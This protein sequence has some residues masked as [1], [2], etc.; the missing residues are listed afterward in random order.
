MPF[1]DD[2]EL[3]ALPI[4]QAILDHPF[5]RGVGDGSLEV[6]KFKHYVLQDYVYLIEYSR[7]LAMAAARAQD[8]DTMGWFAR[9]LD[10]TLNIEMDL[11]RGYCAEFGITSVE[12]ETTVPAPTTVAYTAYLLQLAHQGSFAELVASLVPCQWGYWEIGEYLSRQGEPEDAPLYSQWIQ[13]YT[14]QEF[15]ELADAIR[16]LLDRLGSRAGPDELEAMERAYLTSLRFEYMF[17][18]MAYGLETWPV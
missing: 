1:A 12:L 11:H 9:L 3:K 18:E 8:L 5:V 17:W 10:E 13:M 4:R 14:S 6:E 16:S 15:A 2:L 7:V